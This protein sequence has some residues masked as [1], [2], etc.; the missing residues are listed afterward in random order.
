ML[1]ILQIEK[2]VWPGMGSEVVSEL[3]RRK[4]DLKH[5]IGVLYC[6]QVLK[7]SSL[8]LGVLDMPQVEILIAYFDGLVGRRAKK[9]NI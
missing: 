7:S 4:L 9:K 2:M 1:S 3:Y 6:G 5:Y 8:M